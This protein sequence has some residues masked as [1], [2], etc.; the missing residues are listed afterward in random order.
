VGLIGVL[1][2][3]TPKAVFVQRESTLRKSLCGLLIVRPIGGICSVRVHL[4]WEFYGTLV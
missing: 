2:L 3:C 1:L 4:T